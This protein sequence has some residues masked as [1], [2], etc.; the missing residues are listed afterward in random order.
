MLYIIL[1]KLQLTIFIHVLNRYGKK[2]VEPK[3]NSF[4]LRN[5]FLKHVEEQKK[6]KQRATKKSKM[7]QLYP[8]MEYLK[9]AGLTFEGLRRFLLTRGV[10][11]TENTL[12]P[13]F[14]E[15]RKL[16]NLKG[17]DWSLQFSSEEMESM[18]LIASNIGNG[19]KQTT[20]RLTYSQSQIRRHKE[21]I[22]HLILT[23]NASFTSVADFYHS[24]GLRIGV[25]AFKFQFYRWIKEDDVKARYSDQLTE[26][27]S[28]RR[29]SGS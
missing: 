19:F 1:C 26:R 15:C 18:N 29:R 20:K 23:E 11:V 2:Q 4:E 10:K 27:E 6:K 8:V 22:L 13:C 21:G 16:N 5:E 24:K 25:S 12:K 28:R 9:E 7:V 3:I 17:A 14:Y